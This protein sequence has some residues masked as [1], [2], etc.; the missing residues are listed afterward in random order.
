M[1]D[2]MS[3]SQKKKQIYRM[4]DEMSQYNMMDKLS[5]RKGQIECQMKCHRSQY[6]TDKISD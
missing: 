4:P 5:K 6:L 2:K 1:T 3:K